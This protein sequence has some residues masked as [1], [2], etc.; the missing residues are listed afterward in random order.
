MKHTFNQSIEG[1]DLAGFAEI[2]LAEA[3]TAIEPAYPAIV[4]IYEI[5]ING[6]RENAIEILSPALIHMIEQEIA[7]EYW[8]EI[9]PTFL[10]RFTGFAR[11]YGFGQRW[12][13]PHVGLFWCFNQVKIM[14]TATP[15]ELLLKTNVN[16]HTEK[17]GK[18]TYLSW[19]WAWAE[20]LKADPKATFKTKTFF[21]DQYSEEPYMTLPDGTALVWV[22][23]T[24]F[25][26][27]MT[28]QLPVMN[29]MNK[30]IVSPNSFDVNTSIMRCMTKALSLHGLGLYIYAGEDLPEPNL[31]EFLDRINACSDETS[32]RAEYVLAYKTF[33][34]NDKAQ[35]QIADTKDAKKA[36]FQ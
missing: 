18:L 11:R 1:Y 9:H 2:E 12:G 24:M 32:L 16:A 22:T 20:A 36:S 3:A 35:N 14:T 28:C 13:C 4:T 7:L 19:A 25:D 21:R 27:E 33:E 6:S 26:K 30:P 17:K 34:G 29:H 5:F 8:N 23:V 15:I 31:Q 10:P